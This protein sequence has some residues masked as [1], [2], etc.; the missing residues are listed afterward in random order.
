MNVFG[1][2]CKT[3]GC[4]AWLKVGELPEDSARAIHVP[5][6]IGDGPQ[7]LQCP[8]CGQAHDYHFFEKEILR[9]NPHDGPSRPTGVEPP[10]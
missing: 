10:T 4:Q 5:I 8:D 2:K 7:R 6:T 9:N 1:F 3:P